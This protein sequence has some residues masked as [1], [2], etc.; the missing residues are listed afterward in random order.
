MASP[1]Q[2]CCL[3]QS[4]CDLELLVSEAH[5]LGRLGE[6][7]SSN[8]PA[9]FVP[10]IKLAAFRDGC[11]VVFADAPTWATRLR[12]AAPEILQRLELCPQFISVKSIRVR[13]RRTVDSSKRLR[14][15][16]TL[17]SQ[18][19]AALR[20]QATLTRDFQVRAALERLARNNET[21]AI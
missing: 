10:H 11:L 16:A 5:R 3:L 19:A 1:I 20:Q 2:L 6:I 12:Y 15:S 21:G 7:F 13:L 18:A 14:R 8:L 4:N 17:T 9:E